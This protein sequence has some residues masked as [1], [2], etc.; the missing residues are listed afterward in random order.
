MHGSTQGD[1]VSCHALTCSH[2]GDSFQ[3][4]LVIPDSNNNLPHAA[5]QQTVWPRSWGLSLSVCSSILGA[6]AP[7]W[8]RASGR[9]KRGGRIVGESMHHTPSHRPV[10]SDCLPQALDTSHHMQAGGHLPLALGAHSQAAAYLVPY[11]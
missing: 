2:P 1:W 10:K 3:A 5:P 7:N 4:P 9:G 8:C 11:L 6:A